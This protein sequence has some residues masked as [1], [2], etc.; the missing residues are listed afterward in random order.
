LILAPISPALLLAFISAQFLGVENIAMEKKT[1]HRSG[2]AI[3]L[4]LVGE[5]SIIVRGFA[6]M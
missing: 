3:L 5:P 2:E 6:A 4:R 1:P